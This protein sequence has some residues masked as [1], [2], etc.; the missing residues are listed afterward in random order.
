MKKKEMRL[1]FNDADL[2]EKLD[3][4]ASEMDV[5]LNFLVNM[6]CS[7]H[8]FE[9]DRKRLDLMMELVELKRKASTEQA[10]VKAIP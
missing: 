1:Q 8:F 5:S 3:E 2:K 6:I 4:L 7:A 9:E 10:P